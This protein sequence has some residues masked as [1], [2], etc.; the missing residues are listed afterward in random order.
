MANDTN[1]LHR[2]AANGLLDRRLVLKTL[3]LSA[4]A[5]PALAQS[6]RDGQPEWPPVGP[7]QGSQEP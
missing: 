2:V 3:A 1:G 6:V 7:D 4:A 5:T